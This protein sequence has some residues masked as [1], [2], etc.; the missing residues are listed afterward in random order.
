MG[1]DELYYYKNTESFVLNGTI[2]APFTYNT[3]GAKFG[4]ADAHG[5]AYSILNGIFV[6]CF[7]FKIIPFINLLIY[8]I[9]LCVILLFKPISIFRRL[10]FIS[11]VNLLVPIWYYLFGLYQETINLL[12]GL[13]TTFMIYKIY[14]GG[15]LALNKNI[16]IFCISLFI[17][18][19]FR[20]SWLVFTIA[21]L[22][23]SRNRKQLIIYITIFIFSLIVLFFLGSLLFEQFPTLLNK[24]LSRIAHGDFLKAFYSF[25]YNILLGLKHYFINFKDNSFFQIINKYL[26]FYGI[27]Y[28]LNQ[29]LRK[30]D[31]LALA[32]G[33]SSVL[34]FLLNLVLITN[35]ESLRYLSFIYLFLVAYALLRN[36]RFLILI[37]LIAELICLPE[38]FVINRQVLKE[39]S[40]VA[41]QFKSD[42]TFPLIKNYLSKNL[43]SPDN[44]IRV[45]IDYSEYDDFR[46]LMTL[47]VINSSGKQIKYAIRY[48]NNNFNKNGI[49]YCITKH[50]AIP[51]LFE[52]QIMDK[53][54]EDKY[55][56]LYKIH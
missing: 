13:L 18:S 37:L 27:I 47:P 24:N 15:K 12:F 46:F 30:K 51:T 43:D 8:V 36:K 11:L 52:S 14:D 50:G 56:D 54:F 49:N 44:E 45:L 26:Y 6:K 32:L 35:D 21:L 29:G 23:L 17:F 7:G 34:I 25:A 3:D 42:P 31:N 53:I 28:L 9:I 40:M 16:F 39:R 55:F 20:P 48:Y 22:P 10:L 4:G 38:A 2:D 19:L 5:P 41:N 33:V 1:S